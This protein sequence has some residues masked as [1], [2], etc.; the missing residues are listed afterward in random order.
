MEELAS[1]CHASDAAQLRADALPVHSQYDVILKRLNDLLQQQGTDLSRS[2]AQPTDETSQL[3]RSLDASMAATSDM[4]QDTME[5]VGEEAG[6][7]SL[8]F[9]LSELERWLKHAKGVLVTLRTNPSELVHFERD[10]ALHQQ[11]VDDIEDWTPRV[12]DIRSST[13]SIVVQS[14][15]TEQLCERISRAIQDW[16]SVCARS[17][18]CRRTLGNLL[19]ISNAFR[20][21]IDNLLARMQEAR[22]G[23]VALDLNRPSSQRSRDENQTVLVDLD[24]IVRSI[25]VMDWRVNRLASLSDCLV[26][27][28]RPAVGQQQIDQ[29]DAMASELMSMKAACL[30]YKSHITDSKPAPVDDLAE[31]DD[32]DDGFTQ[33]PSLCYRR[34]VPSTSTWAGLHHMLGGQ[35]TLSDK[36][37]EEEQVGLLTGAEV[38]AAA[39]DSLLTRTKRSLWSRAWRAA[40]PVQL[41]GLIILGLTAFIPFC[42]FCDVPPNNFL[43]SLYPLLR[44]TDGMPPI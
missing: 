37:C 7:S 42:D 30:E 17:S 31:G 43:Y 26:Y 35:P 8:D 23:V 40:I 39:S 36:R 11:L 33:L 5:K 27:S 1:V 25:D 19:M 24:D 21:S 2:A 29:L 28:S 10:L 16:D 34:V 38:P 4:L 20:F 18:T 22:D 9:D 12:A 32:S 44:Y 6:D 13:R 3:E 41:A 14:P 15:H